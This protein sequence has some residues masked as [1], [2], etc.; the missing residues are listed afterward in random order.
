MDLFAVRFKL[1]VYLVNLHLHWMAV[2]I[3]AGCHLGGLWQ[4][5]SNR[6]LPCRFS[7]Y[8]MLLKCCD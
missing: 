4:S 1:T 6:F 2:H 5:G 7:L 8:L 3:F